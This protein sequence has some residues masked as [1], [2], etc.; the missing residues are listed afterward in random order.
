VWEVFLLLNHARGSTGFGPNPFT[1]TDIFTVLT[2]YGVA[3]DPALSEEYI[4]LLTNMD[5]EWMKMADEKHNR[6]SKKREKK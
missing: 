4:I 6:E 1:I 5:A 3:K 2:M